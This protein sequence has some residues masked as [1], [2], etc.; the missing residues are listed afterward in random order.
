MYYAI[1]K[2]KR[3]TEDLERITQIAEWRAFDL[4][5][6]LHN[7][8]VHDLKWYFNELGK[9]INLACI[10]TQNQ[11]NA[12]GRMMKI[13][14]AGI[15]DIDKNNEAMKLRIKRRRKGISNELAVPSTEK[16]I[17]AEG[18]VIYGSRRSSRLN[19]TSTHSK[20]GAH[21]DGDGKENCEGEAEIS[22]LENLLIYLEDNINNLFKDGTKLLDAKNINRTS[23]L[24][25]LDSIPQSVLARFESLWAEKISI[26]IQTDESWLGE[27][28]S[29]PN[30]LK[31]P[32]SRR[33]TIRPVGN[34]QLVKTI[35]KFMSNK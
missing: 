3:K 34:N 8:K 24:E 1:D 20:S 13:I 19:N 4:K 6:L 14:S 26:P 7:D 29:T 21:D 17:D 9:N 5:S 12:M 23:I 28:S 15:P 25:I 10:E 22:P 35:M 16:S 2:I 27:I 32:N 31:P 30:L 11:I 18:N 33:M